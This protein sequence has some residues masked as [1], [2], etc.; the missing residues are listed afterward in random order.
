MDDGTT[1]PSGSEN[2]GLLTLGTGFVFN[3]PPVQIIPS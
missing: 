1:R 2:Y 3:V